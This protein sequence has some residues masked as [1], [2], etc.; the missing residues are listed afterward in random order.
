MV[1]AGLV[2]VIIPFILAAWVFLMDALFDDG[3]KCGR[4]FECSAIISDVLVGGCV[5]V[6]LAWPLLYLL[7]VRPAWPVAGLAVFFLAVIWQLSKARWSDSLL[8]IVLGGLTYP[9]P[10][11]SSHHASTGCGAPCLSLCFSCSTFS[12]VLFPG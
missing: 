3:E 12:A 7:R 9:S 8:L 4:G 11:W 5:A 10:P 6:V 2:A 1:S